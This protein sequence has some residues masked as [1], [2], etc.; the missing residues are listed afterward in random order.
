M[1]AD[2]KRFDQPGDFGGR[3]DDPSDTAGGTMTLPRSLT[4]PRPPRGAGAV[5][6]PAATAF[7]LAGL[8][9]FA[10]APAGW[11]L[12]LWHYTVS[13][14]M[15]RY[16]AYI[17]LV[18]VASA[19]V[20]LPAWVRLSAAR[21]AI[22]L[23]ALTV[24]AVV[25]AVPLHYAWLA[26]AT[27]AIHDITTDPVNPPQFWAVLPSRAEEDA[28][29]VEYGGVA[30]AK[31]QREY[32]PHIAPL[33]TTLP[34]RTA[35]AIALATAKAMP[36]WVDVIAEPEA[37]RIEASQESFWMRFTDDVSIRVSPIVG[38]SRIDVR[39]LS[40]QGRGDFGVNAARVAAYLDALGARLS[41]A[42][43]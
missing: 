10:A 3:R 33:T 12:G 7:T 15:M 34:P 24:A 21:R 40:R 43:R 27:P 23:V 2:A 25:V 35:F 32:Y 22:V 4:A 16:A 29:P 14:A 30:V 13:F 18:A 38:G 6:V 17:G 36:G 28:N 37:W 11:R 31:L 5:A 9:V 39:S 26:A 19:A 8:A 41:T 20:A 1:A 42:R